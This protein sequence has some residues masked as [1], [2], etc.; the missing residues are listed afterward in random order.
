MRAPSKLSGNKKL[1]EIEMKKTIFSRILSL[2]LCFVLVAAI[3]LVGSGCGAKETKSDTPSSSNVLGEGET[4]FTVSIT[5]SDGSEKAYTVN[6]DK[7]TVGEA[8]KEVELIS[9]EDGMVFTVDGETVKYEDGGKYW[10]F[11]I[12]GEYAMTGV[13]A[14]EITAGATYS[15][16][17]E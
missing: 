12:D 13:D 5:F 6:T 9:G 8:L 1:G 17:V 7:K 11:Y 2:I 3:A 14:T 16:K 4:E 15:F 10:A